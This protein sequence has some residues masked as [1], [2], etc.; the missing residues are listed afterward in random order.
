MRTYAAVAIIG[1]LLAIILASA[2]GQAV[3]DTLQTVTATTQ[4][5]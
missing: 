4:E 3:S 2:I 5:D 1:T